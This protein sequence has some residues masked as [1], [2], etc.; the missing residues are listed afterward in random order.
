MKYLI[1][2]LISS[3]MLACAGENKKDTASPATAAPSDNKAE[4][5]QSAPSASGPEHLSHYVCPDRCKGSGGDAPGKCPVCGKDYIHNDLFHQ[6]SGN[7]Q[8]AP[9]VTPNLNTGQNQ[10]NI[11]NTQKPKIDIEE[12]KK[13][14]PEYLAHYVCPSYCKG[15]GGA[16]M[17]KCPKC[18]KDYIHNDV[19]H[20]LN[21]N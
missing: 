7:Q 3:M 12:W 5:S 21:A 14:G 6:Q 1:V 9:V 8:K 17:G 13:K 20:Q 15:S 2:I 18:G 16:E 10:I 11:D 4:T 19:Y